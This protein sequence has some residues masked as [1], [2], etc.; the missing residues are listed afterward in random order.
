LPYGAASDPAKDLA[1]EEI[2]GDEPLLWGRPAWGL[3]VFIAAS[4]A[5]TG[6]GVDF[7]GRDS[8]APL[9]ALPLRPGPEATTPL[10]ADLTEAA[11]NALGDAGLLPLACRRGNDR[12]FAAG[13]ATV[14]KAGKGEPTTTLR[15][16][17]FAAPVAAAM[18]SLLGHLDMTCGMEEIAR[19]I[20]AALQ[21]MG[22]AEGGAVYAASAA[23]AGEGRPAVAVRIRPQGGVLHG[24][25]DLTFEVPIALH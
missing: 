6:W 9:E 4:F 3:G 14:Y 7:A 17:L 18:E 20:G 1:F 15:Y 2:S 21:I 16:A 10:E 5:R 13:T 11:A 12:P 8:A 19:T 22:M 25:P 23:P 24:L